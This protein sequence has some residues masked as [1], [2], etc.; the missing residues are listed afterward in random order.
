MGGETGGAEKSRRFEAPK[1]VSVGDVIEVTIESQGG[2]GDGIAKTNGFV[3][4]VKGTKKGDTC[5]IR[6]IDVKRTYAVGE[7][8]R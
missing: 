1:P 3:V 6:I 8:H 4:F 5:K 7:V 2:Q